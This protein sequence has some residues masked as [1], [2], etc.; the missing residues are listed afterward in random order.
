MEAKFYRCNHC[1]NLVMMVRDSGVNPVCCGEEMELLVAGSVDASLE[2]H[3][4]V[5]RSA[6]DAVRVEIG[7]LP[8]PM[9]EE[10]HIEWV[11]LMGPGHCDV[12]Y[13]EPGDGPVAVF[14]PA[15][16]GVVYAYCNLHGL[17]EARF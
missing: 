13:L 3:V 7:A 2:K 5:V 9:A 11:A 15:E 4:P 14:P 16:H 12:R 10:H 1:G 17:W 6:P 8:H